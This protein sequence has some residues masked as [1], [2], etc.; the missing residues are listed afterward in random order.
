MV[1]AVAQRA[2]AGRRPPV[3][4]RVGSS[5][6][7]AIFRDFKIASR[8]PE[9]GQRGLACIPNVE[10]ANRLVANLVCDVV[11][12]PPQ[13]AAPDAGPYLGCGLL[14]VKCRN[15]APQPAMNFPL[16]WNVF[17]LVL[18]A[19]LGFYTRISHYGFALAMPAFA[20]AVYL[21]VWLLPV[22]LEQRYRSA[23]IG[24]GSRPVW[25]W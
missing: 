9:P 24:F 6:K 14:A 2:E 18:L 3:H 10:N 25:C 19:K 20:G 22:L 15:A 21:L 5:Q 1:R 23:S 11:L 17:G 16:L 4:S 12:E 8:A 7:K 13:I